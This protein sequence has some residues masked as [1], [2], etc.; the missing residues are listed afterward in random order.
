[1]GKIIIEYY[2]MEAGYVKNCQPNKAGKKPL[3]LAV[4]VG[5]VLD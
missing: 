1:M 3:T 2:T 4:V 5:G